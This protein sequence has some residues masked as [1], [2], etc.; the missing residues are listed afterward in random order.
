MK[1]CY[2]LIGLWLMLMACLP[3]KAIHLVGGEVSYTCVGNNRYAVKFIIYRDCRNPNGAQFDN[4][5][6]GSI[7]Y[8][9]GQ[10][11]R[12]FNILIDQQS[13]MAITSPDTCTKFPNNLCLQKAIYRDTFNL[14]PASTGYV[15]SHQRCC[16]NHTITNVTNSGDY[17]N[18]YTIAIPPNDTACNSSAVF[19]AE[20]P[21]VLCLNQTVDIDNSV[22]GADGDSVYYSLCNA[23]QG[24]SRNDPKPG[25][26]MPP[27]YAPVPYSSGFSKTYP[28]TSNP[29]FTIDHQTGVLSGRPTAVG[30]YVF[31][32]C[33]SEY[34]NGVLLSVNR[35]DFQFNVSAN[36][37]ATISFIAPQEII[38]ANICSGKN[39]EF[40]SQSQNTNTVL[41]DFGDPTTDRDT[42]RIANP[43]YWYPDTGV[44]NVRL[45]ANPG[46]ACAD[47]SFRDFHVYDSTTVNFTYSGD[48]CL[49]AN[50]FNFKTE[51][52]FT[53]RADFTWD[54]GGI[55][56]AHNGS[57][58]REPRGVQFTQAGLHWV[59]VTVKDGFCEK[60][61]RDT[62]RVIQNPIIRDSVPRIISCGQATVQFSDASFAETP[63]AHFWSFGDGFVSGK[64]N[65]EHT[66]YEPG[67][68]TVTHVIKTS[69]GCKDSAMKVYPNAI[70]IRP[71]PNSS[72]TLNTEDVSIYRPSIEFLDRSEGFTRSET[73]ISDGRMFTDLEEQTL[74]FQDTGSYYLEHITYNE[75][76]CTD[77]LSDTVYVG[78][79]FNIFVPNAFSPDGDGINDNFQFTV[80]NARWIE[81]EI[82]DRWGSI[83]FRSEDL[84]AK[85]DGR[86]YLSNEKL[87]PG[88]YSF[89][90][91]V[92]V[93]EN[94]Y[95]HREMG[96]VML[97]R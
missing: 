75:V 61:F 7:Y 94:G 63:I 2:K 54:F 16:R 50:S 34:R 58:E 49:E 72:F 68:Y 97:L 69:S 45:I 12:D 20:P 41:W 1:N 13:S 36:C 28:I 37:Q 66:Y 21:V 35:R 65:P 86:H 73:Y 4:P 26:A 3:A 14:P 80:T 40:R 8:G 71:E 96:S 55:T 9:N 89:V 83:V 38:P 85:W 47:T 48:P 91:V 74:E 24:A 51:G 59:S 78:T 90:M 76:G 31:A 18:T 88:I 19:N 82:Y 17:G 22:S 81:L 29:R 57:T 27:P 42:S 52:H 32:V 5:L 67:V 43:N 46:T 62:I 23:F 70:E 79:P 33:A 95:T 84:N 53:S 39:I 11:L 10:K 30:Q 15:I 44:Y 64:P 92:R 60:T 77:T 87:S 6:E 56:R 25:F 93:K